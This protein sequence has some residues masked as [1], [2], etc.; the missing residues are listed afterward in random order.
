MAMVLPNSIGLTLP[1]NPPRNAQ[2]NMTQSSRGWPGLQCCP[3][4]MPVSEK[5]CLCNKMIN[6]IHSTCWSLGCCSYPYHS[7][8]L[9]DLCCSCLLGLKSEDTLWTL[10]DRAA[11]D[12]QTDLH[13]VRRREQWTR[14][15]VH[16]AAVFPTESDFNCGGGCPAGVLYM[17]TWDFHQPSRLTSGLASS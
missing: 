16:P 14:L 12:L 13:S 6:V 17:C 1:D 9:S 3:W 11:S 10:W 8:V 2:R 7:H 5:K 15:V 4:D